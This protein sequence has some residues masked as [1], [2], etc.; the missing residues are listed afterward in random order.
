VFTCTAPAQPGVTHRV[1]VV[2]VDTTDRAGEPAEVTS[3][4]VPASSV[5]PESDGELVLPSGTKASVAAGKTMTVSGSGYA[6]FST[7]TVLVYSEPHILT[8][9]VTDGT[10]AFSVEVTVPAGLPAGQH[11]VVAAG[12]DPSGELR[13]LTLPVT[14]TGGDGNGAAGGGGGATLAY[15]GA[16]V[17]VPAIGGLLAVLVG[18]GLLFV[19]RRRP[20]N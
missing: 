13:Y 1:V 6:P 16:D 19:A 14:V 20:V 7:V 3:G 15:T 2:A 12:V 18:A 9:V 11:H 8:T 10:G 17:V 4:V 5:L